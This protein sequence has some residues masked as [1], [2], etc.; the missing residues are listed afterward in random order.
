MDK[1]YDFCSKM[2]FF[3]TLNID[4]FS[5][6]VPATY[7]EFDQKNLKTWP[8][9]WEKMK[10]HNTFLKMKL[11]CT[12]GN[13]MFFVIDTREIGLYY[14]ENRSSRFVN[15][16]Y[17]GENGKKRV[18]FVPFLKTQKTKITFSRLIIRSRTYGRPLIQHKIY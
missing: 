12:M 9:K 1:K 6:V 3:C 8:K 10:I 2:S 15:R 4:N 5:K 14:G 18:F 17:Y 13:L 16:F 11:V 7:G